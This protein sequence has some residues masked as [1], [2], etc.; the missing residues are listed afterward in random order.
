MKSAGVEKLHYR[1]AESAA[2]A[3]SRAA[4]PHD[5]TI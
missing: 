5:L 3:R 4:T 2:V 1:I